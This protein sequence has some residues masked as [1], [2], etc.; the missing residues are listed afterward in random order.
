MGNQGLAPVRSASVQG[1]MVTQC[2]E[3]K[4]SGLVHV[5][6]WGGLIWGARA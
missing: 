6:T 4:P 2:G 5:V 1:E 3:L